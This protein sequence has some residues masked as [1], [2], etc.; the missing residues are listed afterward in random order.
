[1]TL[2][3]LTIDKRVKAAVLYSSVSG[4]FGDIIERWGAGCIGNVFDGEVAYGCNSSDVLPVDIPHSLIS[5]YFKASADPLTL[6]AV[7]PLYH[8]ENVNA[9]VQIAYGTKDGLVSSGT[10]P[11]WS[12]EI[13]DAFIA[14]DKE[15]QLFAYQ[16]EKH[17]F[18]P[19]EWFAFMER[20]GRFFDTYVK[21]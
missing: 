12:Q 19:K 14:A 10:P 5:A 7:S 6:K 2:K 9:P 4:D 15:A 3:V 20:C 13:Y 17:S 16:D 18:S 11:E 8:L 1:V 21:S